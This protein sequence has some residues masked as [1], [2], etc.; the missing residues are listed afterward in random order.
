MLFALALTPIGEFEAERAVNGTL[1]LTIKYFALLLFDIKLSTLQVILGFIIGYP[2]YIYT[3]DILLLFKVYKEYLV[4]KISMICLTINFLT[5]MLLLH[6]G[7]TITGA[8][9]GNA[10]AQVIALCC[11]LALRKTKVEGKIT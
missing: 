11:Y 10:A 5:S 7:Y 3:L 8:L 2:C 6:L 1:G 4:I 9:A